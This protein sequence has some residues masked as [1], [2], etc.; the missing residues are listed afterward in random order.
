MFNRVVNALV[1]GFG[2]VCTSACGGGSHSEEMELIDH[3]Q[4]EEEFEKEAE[5]FEIIKVL[6]YNIF[7]R[8]CLF[9]FVLSCSN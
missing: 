7:I 1:T 9:Y 6:S 8:M 3:V 5:S 4:V 2:Y